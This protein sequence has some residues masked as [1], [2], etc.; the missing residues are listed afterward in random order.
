MTLHQAPALTVDDAAKRLN[1]E[2]RNVQYWA[3]RGELEGVK[4]GR[5]WRFTEEAIA[6][7]IKERGAQAG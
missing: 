6:A 5:E 7:F 3:K 1:T 4:V 2:P